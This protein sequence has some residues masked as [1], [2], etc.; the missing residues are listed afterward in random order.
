[1][2]NYYDILGLPNTASQEEVKKTY[3]KLAL[4]Y[5]PDKNSSEEATEKFKNI[6]E[7]YNKIINGKGITVKQINHED[8]F[9]QFFGNMRMQQ[10]SNINISPLPTQTSYV[11][12]QIQIVNG[13]VIET[14]TEKKN[15]VTRTKTIIREQ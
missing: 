2:P 6:T 8:I 11:S 10:F 14:I 5:H 3:K 12:K 9:K 15:G 1:M 4:K 7:A 13:K